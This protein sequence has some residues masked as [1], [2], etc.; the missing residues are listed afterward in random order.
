MN[1]DIYGNLMTALAILA[2]SAVVSPL[3][4]GAK[5]KLAGWINFAL[6]AT[7]AIILL[8]TSYAVIFKAVPQESTVIHL[9]PSG[10]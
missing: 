2:A 4:A 6:V 7:A 3:I 10:I 1:T 8:H 9:G 5:R